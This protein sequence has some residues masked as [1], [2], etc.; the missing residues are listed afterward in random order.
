MRSRGGRLLV[1]GCATLE[2]RRGSLECPGGVRRIAA[3]RPGRQ[4]RA[5]LLPGWTSDARLCLVI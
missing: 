5:V 4:A 1:S 3:R 2:A